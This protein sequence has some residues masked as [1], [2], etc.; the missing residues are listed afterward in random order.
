M[1]F[2]GAANKVRLYFLYSLNQLTVVVVQAFHKACFKC[3]VCKMKLNPA[4][5]C[6]VSDTKFYCKPHYMA[7]VN[8]GT[9]LNDLA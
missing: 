5:Y 8:S 6:C 7:L 4:N 1:E 9:N 3:E 2:V